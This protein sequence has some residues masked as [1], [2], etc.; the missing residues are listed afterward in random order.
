MSSWSGTAGEIVT[1]GVLLA[2]TGSESEPAALSAMSAARD[3]VHVVR[4]CMDLA[5][6]LATA[7]TRQASAVVVTADFRGLDAATVGRLADEDLV[8][9][10]VVGERDSADHLRLRRLGVTAVLSTPEL[11]GI[12]GFV[13]TTVAARRP[14]G[15][16]GTAAA[17]ARAGDGRVGGP[18]GTG[19]QLAVWGPTGAPGRSTVALGLAAGLARAGLSTLLVDA[20]VYGGSVAQQLGVLDEVSGLLATCRSANRG[21]LTPAELDRHA[22]AVDDRLT[23]LTGLPRADRWPELRPVLVASVLAVARSVSAWTVVDCGFSLEV[24]EG[25]SHD[26]SAPRRNGATIAILQ[27]VDEVVVVG[28]ADPVGLARLA[29]GLAE[30]DAV[31]RPGGVRIVVN[32]YRPGLRW[33]TDEIRELLGRFTPAGDVTVL[34]EDRAACDQAVVQGRTLV[35]CAT[36]SPL[37]TALGQL[38]GRLCGVPVTGSARR[39]G[40]RRA[41]AAT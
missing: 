9:V 32:R 26:T 30:L 21:E 8:L 14:A 10:G 24:D 13:A 28:A 34:P 25:L 37:T 40:W 3:S 39:F 31:V 6:L 1:V 11:D 33:S 41:A 15:G 5:D 4:R 36:G 29:R 7:A 23:V 27:A 16:V 35:E 38:A 17:G 18:A 19:R 20:D 12:G 2:M 22:R